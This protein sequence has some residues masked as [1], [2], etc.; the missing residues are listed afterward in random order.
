L[1]SANHEIFIKLYAETM[2]LQAL[3][4]PTNAGMNLLR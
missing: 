3:P 1:I 4:D 2:N